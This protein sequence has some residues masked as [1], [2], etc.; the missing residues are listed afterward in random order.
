MIFSHPTPSSPVVGSPWWRPSSVARYLRVSVGTLANWRSQGSGPPW[1]KLP[2]GRIRYAAEAVTWWQSQG[3][4]PPL[5]RNV[6]PFRRPA[7]P[8]PP[9]PPPGPCTCTQMTRCPGAVALATR[10]LR[11]APGDPITPD[12]YFAHLRAAQVCPGDYQPP[13]LE[14]SSHGA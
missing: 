10:I 1:H 13:A 6:L 8:R 9:L 2:N 4:S 3:A 14:E 5:P 7:T 12:A 11:A